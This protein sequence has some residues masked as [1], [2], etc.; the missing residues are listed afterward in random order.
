MADLT[1]PLSTESL[2]TGYFRHRRRGEPPC[3]EC[4]SRMTRYVADRR[5]A[6]GRSYKVFLITCAFCGVEAEVSKPSAKCCSARCGVR[7]QYGHSANVAIVHQPTPRPTFVPVSASSGRTFVAGRCRRCD[8]PFTIVDQLENRHCSRR[9]ARADQRDRRRAKKRKAF[10]A[11][12]HRRRIFE[13]DGWRCG[14][15]GRAVNRRAAVPHPRAPVLDHIIPLAAGGTHEPANVQCAH[16][17][18]NSVK[19]EGAMNDQLRLIG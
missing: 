9:C 16:F 6:T 1:C 19:S 17:L 5:L 8:E 14:L 10:V 13:R 2:V 3:R 12:V 11:P 15:C 7:L 18:C 4:T